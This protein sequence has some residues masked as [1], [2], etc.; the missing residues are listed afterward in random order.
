M[1]RLQGRLTRPLLVSAFELTKFPLSFFAG[2]RVTSV[3]EAQ[4]VVQLPGGWRTQNPFRSTYWAAQGMAAEMATGVLPYLYAETCS[5]KIRMILAETE[6]RFV[7][8]CKTKSTFTCA[9]G[10]V[11][12]EA[13]A[14]TAR[15]GSSVACPIDVAGYDAEGDM[16]SEWKFVWSFRARG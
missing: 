13:F 4:C 16:V 9:A 3:D 6:G 7:K 15:T 11:V 5:R 12:R 8:Q 14:E 2:L 10:D 1:T